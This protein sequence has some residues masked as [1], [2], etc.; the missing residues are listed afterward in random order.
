MGNQYNENNF[1]ELKEEYKSVL[2]NS[3][4][5]HRVE[6]NGEYLKIFT[7]ILLGKSNDYLN[8]YLIF[9]D[10]DVG[11]SD[12]NN[13]YAIL[14]DYYKVDDEMLADIADS[15]GL[16]YEEYRFTKWVTPETVLFEILKFQDVV[17]DIVELN[18]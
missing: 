10:G 7:D 2:S 12:S 6:D 4:H 1:V 5:I 15:V 18:K 8:L 3:N 16:D 9:E 14:D 17:D 13:I 11:L